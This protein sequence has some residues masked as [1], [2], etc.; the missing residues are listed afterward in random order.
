MSYDPP[1][2]AFALGNSDFTYKKVILL[3]TLFMIDIPDFVRFVH[4][5]LE[6][7]HYDKE[8]RR[9]YPA[10]HSAPLCF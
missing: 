3:L 6:M 1:I 8:G 5:P 7:L 4:K 2:R 10:A 9:N